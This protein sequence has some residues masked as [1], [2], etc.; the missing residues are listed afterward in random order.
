MYNL[1]MFCSLKNLSFTSK[2]YVA[3]NPST[4][5]SILEKLSADES[6]VVR[7]HVACNPS[8]PIKV[9][10]KLS[11]DDNDIIRYNVEQ[12]LTWKNRK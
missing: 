11:T 9:L 10:E 1:A 7:W 2:L 5:V 8:T 12:N 6:R 3:H 4:P